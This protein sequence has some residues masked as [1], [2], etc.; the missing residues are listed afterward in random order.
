[1]EKKASC[2]ASQTRSTWNP[3]DLSLTTEENRTRERRETGP[4]EAREL[5]FDQGNRG[6]EDV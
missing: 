6:D 2:S 1:M 3:T 5:A 4:A